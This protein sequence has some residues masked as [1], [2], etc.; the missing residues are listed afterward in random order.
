MSKEQKGDLIKI[1]IS[2]LFFVLALAFKNEYA[3]LIFSVLSF[4]ICGWEV[5]AGAAKNI[6]HGELFDECFLMTLATIGAFFI[7]EIE[8]AAAVMVF[9][10]TGEF[11]G[12]LAVSKTR[13]S[14]ADLMDICP[15]YAC[16]L[17]DNEYLRIDLMDV[18]KGDV[19]LI[20]PGEKIPVDCEVKDGISDV[21]T[22]AISGES[23]PISAE[24]G[25]FLTGGSINLNGVLKAC[26][27]CEFSDSTVSKILELTEKS[28][29]RK[30]KYESFIRRFAK[31][32]TP[33]VVILAVLVALIPPIFT[34]N[35]KEWI[36]RGISFLV[37]SCPCALVLSIPLS[38][39][40]GLGR[41]SAM[42]ILVK[43]ANYLENLSK[44]ETIVFDKTGTLTKGCF[45]IS[46][47]NAVGIEESELLKIS[48]S[49]EQFSNHPIS[50]AIKNSYKG[51]L[52]KAE[53]V[54]EIAGRGVCAKISGDTF[55]VGNKRLMDEN[56][57]KADDKKL[58]DTVIYV[59][60]GNELLGS[61]TV[62]DKI[63]D[64]A[65]NVIL[66]LKKSGIKK[67]VMLTGDKRERGEKIAAELKI[68]EVYAELLPQD[69]V[70]KLEEI[71]AK[72]KGK[73]AFV[74]DGV[75]DAPVLSLSD[76]AIS[77]GALGQDAAIEASDIVL[78]DDNLAKIPVA[79]TISRKTLSIARQNIVLAIGVKLLVLFLSVFGI[80]SLWFAV[81]ADVGVAI[82]AVLN[83]MRILS[84]RFV[85]LYLY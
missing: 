39:F 31:I 82:L 68:D 30:A 43:G 64:T 5:I 54:T 18:K 44:C 58:N 72:S 46:K 51:E 47:I 60:K 42:G 67:I 69:K 19:L 20:K 38:F 21:D 50:K 14:I 49:L 63:K 37:V 55:F 48:A 1:I 27:L 16:V 40:G 62:S 80:T 3:K 73:V 32:Y 57:V 77:M 10:Q 75:N 36:T 53:G 52:Y 74:G 7:G 9:Y 29:E 2:A 22:S 28:K 78:T 79:I 70:L 33:T 11:F 56:G 24:K 76:V 83:A 45:M 81:F 6:L 65:K 12:H 66:R 84:K 59:A 15:E 26:A 61:I 23:V 35:F 4:L 34:G 13:R 25:V 17:K 8:E 71:K 85:R 41:A